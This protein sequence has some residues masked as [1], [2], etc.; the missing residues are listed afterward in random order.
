[1]HLLPHT[2]PFSLTYTSKKHGG[3]RKKG[4]EFFSGTGSEGEVAQKYVT[5]IRN[6]IDKYHISSITDIGCGDFY[7]GREICKSRNIKYTGID[8]VEELITYNQKRFGTQ[9][10]QFLTLDASTTQAAVS[11]LLLVRQVLQHL[12]NEAI[13]GVISKNF[14]AG[15]SYILV[16][17]D[18][19]HESIVFKKNL[20]ASNFFITARHPYYSSVYLNAPPFN[21]KWEKVLQGSEDPYHLSG[22]RILLNR[23]I[24]TYRVL[25]VNGKIIQP[26]TLSSS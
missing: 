22:K 12:T 20:N 13:L 11:D 5:Y 21:C 17:E 16:T 6:F 23:N 26:T 19:I 1:M 9:D 25:E 24:N 4:E 8:V 14:L 18:Q 15:F 7:I 2:K 3:P 10:I